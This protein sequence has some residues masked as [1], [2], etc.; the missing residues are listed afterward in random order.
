MF[1]NEEKKHPNKETKTA[2]SAGQA[3]LPENHLLSNLSSNN[4][5]NAAA[6]LAALQSAAFLQYHLQNHSLDGLSSQQHQLL[7]AELMHHQNQ[8]QIQQ[9]NQYMMQKASSLHASLNLTKPSKVNGVP[10]DNEALVDST[11]TSL[12]GSSLLKLENESNGGQ[13]PEDHL[14]NGTGV[15]SI[16]NIGPSRGIKRPYLKFSMDAILGAT[17]RPIHNGC[18]SDYLSP[19][20]RVC[21]GMKPSFLSMFF[22]SFEKESSMFLIILKVFLSSIIM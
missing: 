7:M 5:L 4:G 17:S 16:G 8:L 2:G 13:V 10:N 21:S 9:I 18:G 19:I 14:L 3:S 15:G 12:N 20:K 11:L 22:L 1:L 6:A